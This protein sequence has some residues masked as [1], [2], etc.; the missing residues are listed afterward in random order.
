M[1]IV[2]Y[3]NIKN[4]LSISTFLFNY[5]QN[6]YVMNIYPTVFELKRGR[7]SLLKKIFVI[8]LKLATH[9]AVWPLT[10][11]VGGKPLKIKHRLIKCHM[12]E[13]APQMTACGRSCGRLLSLAKVKQYF[14]NKPFRQA[15]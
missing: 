5:Q 10:V 2:F 7:I 11:V 12:G 1:I 9:R 14:S 15:I 13:T 4:K 3:I 6:P 8:L